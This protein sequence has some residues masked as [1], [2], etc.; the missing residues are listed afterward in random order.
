ML[1]ALQCI[2]VTP[3][4]LH[5]YNKQLSRKD[6]WKLYVAEFMF[7]FARYYWFN[8]K[9]NSSCCMQSSK[10]PTTTTM[11]PFQLMYIRSLSTF[12]IFSRTFLIL[13]RY[14][15]GLAHSLI[16]TSLPFFFHPPVSHFVSSFI[17]TDDIFTDIFIVSFLLCVR[18]F[19]NF[20]FLY[21]NLIYH[22]HCFINSDVK[23]FHLSTL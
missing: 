7:P 16:Q 5:I 1:K 15:L 6:I 4:I 11:L 14:F 20:L 3:Y 8:E 19:I 13:Y 9:S 17:F 23:Q 22:R 12:L 18:S 10:H 21:L 2:S